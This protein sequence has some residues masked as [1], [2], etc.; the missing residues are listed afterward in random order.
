MFFC[1]FYFLENKDIAKILLFLNVRLEVQF[2]DTVVSQNFMNGW[3]EHD[4]EDF[5]QKET[6]Q[7][8][9]KKISED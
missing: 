2:N 5:V 8:T 3:T 9:A 4:D 1:G 6:A 7:T